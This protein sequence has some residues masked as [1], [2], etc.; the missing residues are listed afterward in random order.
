MDFAR[1]LWLRIETLHAVTYFGEETQAAGAELGVGGFWAGYFGFR[2]A[3]LGRV[4]P[5]VVD[6]AFF[7]FAPSFVRRWVPDVWATAEPEAFVGARSRAAA[8]TLRRLVPDL[9]GTARVVA[10][11]LDVAIAAGAGAGRPLFT[12]NRDVAL[13]DDPIAALWQR[14][15]VLRE[16]RGDG[17]V[18]AL[19]AAGIDGLEAH[20]L[21]ALEQGTDPTDLQRTRGWTADDWDAAVGRLRERGLVDDAGD[22]SPAGR[23]LRAD[24]ERTTDHLAAH[25]WHGLDEVERT[26][27]VELLTPAATAVSHAGVIRYPNPMGLPPLP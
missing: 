18:A 11:F 8:T 17:H 6:A 1:S 21:I 22:L 2:A 4:E 7:N 26:R 25:P 20:V 5:G 14:C 19:T 10:P 9:A 24:A 3:P 12:A 16:H 23:E 27:V 15:T 13:P